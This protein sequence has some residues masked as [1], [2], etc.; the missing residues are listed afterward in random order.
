MIGYHRLYSFYIRGL[1]IGFDSIR[2]SVA[3]ISLRLAKSTTVLRYH[4]GSL[5]GTE[6]SRSVRPSN[7]PSSTEVLNLPKWTIMSGNYIHTKIIERLFS[8]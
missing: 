7:N 3:I 2:I 6:Y 4:L 8:P 5:N 1:V